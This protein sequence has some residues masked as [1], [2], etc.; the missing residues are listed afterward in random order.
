LLDEIPHIVTP[1]VQQRAPVLR[2]EFG[3]LADVGGVRRN[4]EW[5]KSLLDFQIIEK[6]GKHTGIGFGRHQR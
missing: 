4:G 2:K 6:M 1:G 5:R 3:E